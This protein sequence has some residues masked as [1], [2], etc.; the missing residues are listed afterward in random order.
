MYDYRITAGGKIDGALINAGGV[1]AAI[2]KGEVTRGEVLTAFPFLNAVCDISFSGQ[3][4]WN[5]FEGIA[6]RKS[7]VTNHDVTSFV[8][9]SKTLKFSHNPSNPIGSRLISFQVG[10]TPIDFNKNYTFVSHFHGTVRS[11]AFSL[12]TVHCTLGSCG[13]LGDGW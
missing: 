11:T 10:G 13:F 7:T 5:I 3:Q 4:W 12:L 9:I 6:S 8:Q 1:R 2:D